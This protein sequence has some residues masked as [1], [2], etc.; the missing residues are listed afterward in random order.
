MGA[1]ESALSQ[2]SLIESVFIEL[3]DVFRAKKYQY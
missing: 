2:T 1:T 3:E